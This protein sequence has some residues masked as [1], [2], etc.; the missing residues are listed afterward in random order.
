MQARAGAAPLGR[1]RLAR[2]ASAPVYA[3]TPDCLRK[4]VSDE[5]A[6]GGWRR[7]RLVNTDD[8]IATTVPNLL[9]LES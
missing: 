1:R 5:D 3:E 8:P 4:L 2:D 6:G 9:E 7:R